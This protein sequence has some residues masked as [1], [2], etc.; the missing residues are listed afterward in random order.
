MSARQIFDMLSPAGAKGRLTVLIYHRVLPVPD[1][2]FPE[3]PDAARFATEMQWIQTWL[4]VLPLTEAIERLRHGSLPARAAAITFDDGYADNCTVAL[5]ILRRVGLPATF[6]IATGYLDGGRMWNDTVIDVVRNAKGPVLDLLSMNLGVYSIATIA[7]RRHTLGLLLRAL[8]YLEPRQR[9][10]RV[11]DIA[12]SAHSA[13]ASDLMLTT[14]QVMTMAESGMTIGAHTVSH[15]ILARVAE[16]EAHEEMIQSKRRLESIIGREVSLFAYPNGKPE[17]DY[18]S[19]HAQLARTAGFSAAF[20]TGWGVATRHSDM[21]Q[22]PRFTPWD[23][24]KLRYAL[25]LARNMRCAA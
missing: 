5:P 15:P 16:P 11:N 6:F 8:K 7:D 14:D 17:T 24:A 13:P 18:T 19:T 2:L 9:K 25:R 22:L 23:R 1:P 12:A 21:F 3:E 20:S 10:S 4:N